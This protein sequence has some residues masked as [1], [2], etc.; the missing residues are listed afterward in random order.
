MPFIEVKRDRSIRNLL[1]SFAL[2]NGIHFRFYQ[3]KNSN[4]ESFQFIYK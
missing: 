3:Q 1:K 4:S 2:I